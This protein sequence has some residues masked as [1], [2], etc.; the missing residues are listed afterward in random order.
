[1]RSFALGWFTQIGSIDNAYA[2]A[3][4]MR[5]DFGNQFPTRAW[6]WLWYREMEA[7]RRDPRFT[8]FV[9]GLGMFPYWEKYGPP[10]GCKLNAGRL[11]CQ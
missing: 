8:G 10:D 5:R 9:A 6:A 7:F 2:L 3:E 4:T 11:I 1:M